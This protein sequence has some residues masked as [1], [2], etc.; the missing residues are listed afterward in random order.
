MKTLVTPKLAK[1]LKGIGMTQQELSNLSGVPQGSI[2][3]FDKNTRHDDVHL[4][5]ISK[6]LGIVV[7]ELFEVEYIDES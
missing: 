5:A 3:R 2:S 6:I 4:F 1:I 7:A